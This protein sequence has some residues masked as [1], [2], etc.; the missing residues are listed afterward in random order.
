MQN[1]REN[2]AGLGMDFER[3]RINNQKVRAVSL[4]PR[5]LKN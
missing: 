5:P 1:G 3:L 4:T 2:A